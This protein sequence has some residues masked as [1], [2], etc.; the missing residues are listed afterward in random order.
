MLEGLAAYFIRRGGG[1]P[2]SL[3]DW[4]G[5]NPDGIP[6]FTTDR[7]EWEINNHQLM[8]ANEGSDNINDHD[9][10]KVYQVWDLIICQL[11]PSPNVTD[12]D[13]GD[14]NEDDPL[15]IRTL[16]NSGCLHVAD[17]SIEA[18]V[19]YVQPDCTSVSINGL[20]FYTNSFTPLESDASADE[21]EDD[22]LN[23][24]DASINPSFNIGQYI[25]Y[26]VV[27]TKA[28]LQN[29]NLVLGI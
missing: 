27:K 26:P 11:V 24:I 14:Y 8:N 15:T 16:P 23:F 5:E 4:G 22:A 2:V 3:Y 7:T 29:G 18:S 10:E 21:N 20:I 6:G 19:D 28:C 17:S 13:F 25:R 9:Y 1:E 12:F